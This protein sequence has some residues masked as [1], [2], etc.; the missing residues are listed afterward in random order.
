MINDNQNAEIPE[1]TLLHAAVHVALDE[2]HASDPQW[3]AAQISDEN[4]IS[5]YAKD[6]AE[7]E[8]LA[9]SFL[10]WMAA[11]YMSGSLSAENMESIILAIPA[12]LVY[13]SEQNFNMYPV[14]SRAQAHW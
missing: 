10:M 8:D 5:N 9:E 12:R 7:T 13:L 6:N 3:R 2:N 11:R 4:D 14:G 1:E